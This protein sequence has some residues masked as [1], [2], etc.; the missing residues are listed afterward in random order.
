M[1]AARRKVAASKL[2]ARSAI[3]ST[4]NGEEHT[5]MQQRT[6]EDNVGSL[7][8]SRTALAGLFV[9]DTR[10]PIADPAEIAR[11]PRQNTTRVSSAIG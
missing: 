10:S 9:E 4:T 1:R 8:R 5:T 2:E 11:A 7:G 3:H 6:V